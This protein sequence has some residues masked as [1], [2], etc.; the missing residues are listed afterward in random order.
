[1]LLKEFM[2]RLTINIIGKTID[3]GLQFV[4]R[5]Y[6]NH[7]H[8]NSLKPPLQV[9]A[10]INNWTY[11]E[12]LSA[13]SGIIHRYFYCPGPKKDAPVFL[14]LHGLIFDSRNFINQEKLS[15]T[16]QLIAYDFPESSEAYRGDMND[17]RYLIDD[18]LDCLKIDT[19]YLCGVSFGGGIALRYSAAHIR[20]IK[21]LVLVSSFVMNSSKY[22]RIKSRGIAKTLLKHP[23][24]KIHWLIHTILKFSFS[25]KK[26]PLSPLKQMIHI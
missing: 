6:K 8:E 16:W 1:M 7:F 9:G 17:F 19:L 11:K 5:R 14:F 18:F 25:G 15:D 21:A 4:P 22:D 2:T 3:T 26:N 24:Y 10:K 23:D 20:R 12:L 13:E